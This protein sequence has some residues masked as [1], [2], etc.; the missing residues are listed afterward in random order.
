MVNLSSDITVFYFYS[1]SL[2][3]LGIPQETNRAN[4]VFLN[5]VLSVLNN[6]QLITYIIGLRHKF[7]E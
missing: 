2:L 5:V 3:F 4:R 6:L 7:I 1:T